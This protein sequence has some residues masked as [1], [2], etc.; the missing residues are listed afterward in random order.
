MTPPRTSNPRDAGRTDATPIGAAPAVVR[1]VA[2]L[3]A[4]AASDQEAMTLSEIAR[5]IGVPKSSTSSLCVALEDGGLIVRTDGGYQLGRKLVEL[6][7]A[8]LARVDQVREF[9]E[10]CAASDLLHAETARISVL[11]GT[12]TICLARYEG[13]PA[14]RLTSNIGD[15]FPASASAQGKVLLARLDDDEIRRLYHGVTRLPKLTNQSRDTVDALV[16]DVARARRHGYAMDDEEAADNVVGL[17]VPIPTR[18][19]RSALMA[20]SVT[21]L[22]STYTDAAREALIPEMTRLA[23]RLGSPMQQG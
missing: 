13:R 18:G 4:L 19:T 22:K 6:G 1:A 15:R 14:I 12:D 3:D 17:A 10:L 8:Y 7:G 5:A 23:R 21:Q 2:V 16:G 20:L 9:Y 11:A